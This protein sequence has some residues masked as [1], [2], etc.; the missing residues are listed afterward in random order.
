MITAL[1]RYTAKHVDTISGYAQRTHILTQ[2]ARFVNEKKSDGMYIQIAT[3][4]AILGALYVASN[5]ALAANTL[6]SISNPILILHNIL[7]NQF[8]QA[9]MFIVFSVVAF[10]GIYHLI[11]IDGV[12]FYNIDEWKLFSK[13]GKRE[14]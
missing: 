4:L 14:A 2:H 12:A 13:R 9:I 11:R 6:W 8:E 1:R 3:G 7:S 10:Y 5:R